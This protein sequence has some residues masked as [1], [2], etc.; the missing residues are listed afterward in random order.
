[1]L[2]QIKQLNIEA[3]G[4]MLVSIG[5]P[6]SMYL[7]FCTDMNIWSPFIM[8]LSIILLVYKKII[9]FHIKTEY[10]LLFIFQLIMVCYWFCSSKA[11]IQYL[12]FHFYIIA[13]IFALSTIKRIQMEEVLRYS[14]FFS[15]PLTIFGLIV[16]QLG[17]V[18]GPLA[19]TLRNANEN[20]ALEPFTISSGALIGYYSGLCML[21]K[22]RTEKILI[23]IF[24]G[25]NIYLIWLCQ[26]R[27]PLLILMICTLM[28]HIKLKGFTP[29][30]IIPLTLK[31][32]SVSVI[33]LL[34]LLQNNEF[35]Q[36][37]N[38]FSTNVLNG[39]QNILGNSKVSDSSGSAIVRYEYRTYA[40]NFIKN[41]F[42]IINY[43]YGNGYMEKWKQIDNPIL[44][45]YL[46]MGIIGLVG[47]IGLVIMYPL[48][49]LLFYKLNSYQL[50][51]LFCSLYNV[52][53]SIS[54]GN[55]Y[56]YQKYTPICLLIFS[57]SLTT[58]N[59]KNE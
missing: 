27:T 56:F 25:L 16:C 28:Y 29:Q 51:F 58:K 48:K 4:L 14:F 39:V 53:S 38:K 43:I 2:S 23:L 26:K 49:K 11:S 8:F 57:I 37:F 22:N 24:L 59:S 40:L 31:I 50:Y 34:I 15:I 6:L 12:C 52:F 18:T 47:Y 36:E 10:S 32:I 9:F 45:S 30:I 46:D 44:Q 5:V 35:Y 54:S 20:Y 7:N 17:L 21:K 42:N 55:P 13:L 3:I 33:A 1:M 19:W 41:Q